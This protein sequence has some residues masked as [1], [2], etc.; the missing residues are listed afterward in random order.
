[1]GYFTDKNFISTD[2]YKITLHRISEL[3]RRIY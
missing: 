3:E 2:K 1:M